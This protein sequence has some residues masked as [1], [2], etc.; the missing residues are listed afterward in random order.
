MF[1]WFRIGFLAAGLIILAGAIGFQIY[2]SRRM[3]AASAWPV[4]EGR[5]LE[6]NLAGGPRGGTRR[7][8]SMTYRPRI[9]YEYDVGGRTYRGDRIWLLTESASSDPSGAN[10]LLAA[11]PQGGTGPVRYNPDDP[12][13]SALIVEVALWPL[14]LIFVGV[15]LVFL[16]LGWFVVPWSQRLMPCA[17]NR[18]RRRRFLSPTPNRGE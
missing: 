18:P 6:S 15:G 11:Y 10:D 17:R 13:D 7:G 8:G 1:A 3:A 16:A 14:T 12:A 2:G 4:A 9:S 5:V